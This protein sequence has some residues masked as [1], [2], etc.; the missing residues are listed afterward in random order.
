MPEFTQANRPLQLETPLG[1]DVL[2]LEGLSGE[3]GV[4]TT[5]A[6]TLDLLTTESID[7]A[8]LLRRPVV[9]TI[10]LPDGTERHLH[11]IVRRFTQGERSDDGF[12][13][14]RAEVV[15]W[16][17]FLSLARDCRVFQRMNVIQIAEQVFREAGYKDFRNGC[18]REPPVREYCVQ[19]RESHLDFVSR[20][21]E[22]EGIFYF[23]EH[24]EQKHVLVLADSNNAIVYGK[25]AKSA[26]WLPGVGGT[27][28]DDDIVRGFEREHGVSPGKVTLTDYDYVHPSLGLLRTVA[29]DQPEEVF[30]YPGGYTSPDEGERYA[31][32]QLEQRE[33]LLAVVRGTSN[34]RGFQSGCRFDLKDHYRA[35]VNTSYHLLQVRHQARVGGYRAAYGK[36]SFDYENSFVAIPFKVPY[37]PPLLTPRPVVQGSQTAVVVGP[38]GE[39]IFTDKHGRVKVQFHWDRR[40]K[41]DENS[42]CWVRVSTAWAGKGYG[43]LTIPRIG[44]EVVVDFLEGNP[45][46]PIITGRVYNAE[47]APPY[48]PA[49]GGVVSG[50]RSKTHKGSGYNEMSM[51]DTAGKEMITIHAQ[52]DM[53]STVEHDK[54]ETVK[55]NETI[56]IQNDRTETVLGNE[57]LTVAKD[58]T[59]TVSR[60]ETVSVTLTRTH[61]VGINEAITVGGAQEV[62]VTGFRAVT[63]GGFQNT[64]IGINHSESIG[65][66]H[67]VKVGTNRDVDVGQNDKLKAGKTIA[68]EAGDQITITTGKSSIT[69]KKDG[70]IV[71]EGKDI[72]FKASGKIEGKAS[73]DMIL[74]GSKILQN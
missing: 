47:Q 25:G 73:G 56:E 32:L 64:D 40:G 9:V 34:C 44:Q 53:D 43:G 45:D 58:R 35:D 36:E 11:G 37:R 50:M 65:K 29:G 28:P 72:T 48:D 69:M 55:N 2:L 7:P 70:T 1:P 67:K 63:V 46:A 26:R 6:F 61:N 3:E 57:T 30:D 49:K 21:L 18:L 10:V 5:Y 41:K 23:F 68:I 19:Y 15:P 62:N 66:A 52:F 51:N 27:W 24:S 42:S 20:L 13:A 14:C 31:R 17:W 4:S 71:I 60:N 22:D 54:K 38:K 16:L 12:I 59:R 8:D 33:A 74:K 39:E